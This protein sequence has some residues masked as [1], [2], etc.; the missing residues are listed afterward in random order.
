MLVNR[1]IAA[2]SAHPHYALIRSGSSTSAAWK[3]TDSILISNSPAVVAG[4]ATRATSV[5]HETASRAAGTPKSSPPLLAYRAPI[6]RTPT[7][8]EYKP[9]KHVVQSGSRT[10]DYDAREDDTLAMIRAATTPALSKVQSKSTVQSMQISVH[11]PNAPSSPPLPLDATAD[12]STTISK[13]RRPTKVQS[14]EKDA[15]TIMTRT[16]KLPDKAVAA[17]VSGKI[18]E[19]A[20]KPA[21]T[22][23]KAQRPAKTSAPAEPPIYDAPSLVEEQTAL[24]TDLTNQEESFG[25]AALV[26]VQSVQKSRAAPL[27]TL[28]SRAKIELLRLQSEKLERSRR[29]NEELL[30]RRRRI[31]E[32]LLREAEQTEEERRQDAALKRAKLRASYEGYISL[33]NDFRSA[34]HRT[35]SSLHHLAWPYEQDRRRWCNLEQQARALYSRLGTDVASPT[36]TATRLEQIQAGLGSII[37]DLRDLQKISHLKSRHWSVIEGHLRDNDRSIALLAHQSRALTRPVRYRVYPQLGGH[38]CWAYR[39]MRDRLIMPLTLYCAGMSLIHEELAAWGTWRTQARRLCLV[40]GKYLTIPH[41]EGMDKDKLRA[42]GGS[43]FIYLLRLVRG[44]ESRAIRLHKIVMGGLIEA[45]CAGWI[46]RTSLIE[47]ERARIMQPVSDLLNAAVAV[48]QAGLRYKIGMKRNFFLPQQKKFITHLNTISARSDQLEL[49]AI[50]YELEELVYKRAAAEYESGILQTRAAELQKWS[51]DNLKRQ[52]ELSAQFLLSVRMGR[53]RHTEPRLVKSTR[54]SRTSVAQRSV[55]RRRLQMPGRRQSPKVSAK[56]VT[57]SVS[58]RH[59]KSERSALVV[60]TQ[61]SRASRRRAVSVVTSIKTQPA[62]RMG[63]SK[64]SGTAHSS[65]AVRPSS[66]PKQAAKETSEAPGLLSN[67][68]AE[69]KAERFLQTRLERQRARRR[70]RYREYPDRTITIVEDAEQNSA[71]RSGPSDVSASGVSTMSSSA[72]PRSSHLSFAPT[73][74]LRSSQPAEREFEAGDGNDLVPL[75]EEERLPLS[76]QIP[77]NELKKAMLASP[78]SGAAYWRHTMYRGPQGRQ[79][80]VHYCRSKQTSERVAQMFLNKDVL[81]FDIEWKPNALPF[82]GIKSNVSLMQ[83]ACEDRIA[84]FHLSLH[85]GDTPEDLLA[86]TLRKILESPSIAKVGVAIKADF[87][88]VRKYLGVEPRGV[89][90]LSHLHKLVKY[91]VDSPKKVN[92][93]AVSLA[94]QVE[95]HLQLPLFKGQ[96]RESDWSK[97]LSYEQIRYAASDAYAGFRLYDVLEAKRLRLKPTPPRPFFAELNLPIRLVPDEETSGQLSEGAE[98][99]DVSI[100]FEYDATADE[101]LDSAL[102]GSASGV[103]LGGVVEPARF[104]GAQDCSVAA[105]HQF[106]ATADYSADISSASSNSSTPEDVKDEAVSTPTADGPVLPFAKSLPSKPTPVGRVRLRETD[107]S[108]P[109]NDATVSVQ[110]SQADAWIAEFRAGL[111]EGHVPRASTTC[112]RAYALWRHQS[113]SLEDI[114]VLLRNPPLPVSTVAAYILEPLRTDDLPFDEVRVK[115]VLGCLPLFLVQSRYGTIWRKVQQSFHS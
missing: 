9:A 27:T 74:R 115:E 25:P 29:Q 110:L 33:F 83:L 72:S 102:E 87:N 37:A 79:V 18:E 47:K 107:D 30:E 15:K 81:G 99:D 77:V 76:Y 46:H 24:R 109:T 21:S 31:R 59:V 50:A 10:S 23:V 58:I 49:G 93:V 26:K 43:Q 95:E 111:A 45:I 40:G 65:S 96:V 48:H 86:P 35:L 105:Q 108:P 62:G 5:K 13:E 34:R 7:L 11:I 22:A 16:I 70:S 106:T 2:T 104:N 12:K 61:S 97:Q 98:V 101:S 56:R 39:E 36:P 64:L 71:Q 103:P 51:A 100:G 14:K 17:L 85:K 92:R 53:A 73:P 54:V 57:P 114:G 82:E 55:T 3:P 68:K 42:L 60:Y 112:L 41:V 67:E 91:C 44:A 19:V 88:R 6:K 63:P 94:R 52:R 1:R 113:L 69:E 66:T 78:S 80:A 89:F 32:Q 20:T 38:D 90:E 8:L 75:G 28:F 4:Y 84:L